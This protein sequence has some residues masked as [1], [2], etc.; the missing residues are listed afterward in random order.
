MEVPEDLALEA[1]PLMW[2][3]TAPDALAPNDV[4]PLQPFDEIFSTNAPPAALFEDP[5]DVPCATT[6]TTS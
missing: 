5:F 1:W 2:P 4:P 6:A 3:P